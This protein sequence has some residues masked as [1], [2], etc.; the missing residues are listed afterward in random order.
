MGKKLTK[1]VNDFYVNDVKTAVRFRPGP[2][3]TFYYMHI[4]CKEE[5]KKVGLKIFSPRDDFIPHHL[6]YVLFL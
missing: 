1:L 2:Q 5:A 6:K 4:E 3:Y